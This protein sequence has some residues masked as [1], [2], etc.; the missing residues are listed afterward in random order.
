MAQVPYNPTQQVPSAVPE[1]R[2]PDDYQHLNTNPNMFG[3]GIAQGLGAIGQGIERSSNFLDKVQADNAQAQAIE[4]TQKMLHGTGEIDPATGQIDT[5][6]LGKKGQDALNAAPQFHRDIEDKVNEIR[7]QLGTA[8]ARLLFDQEIRRYRASVI[9][10]Q[11]GTHLDQQ[12]QV[13]GRTANELNRQQAVQMA[14][15]EDVPSEVFQ[16]AYRMAFGANYGDAVLAGG[17]DSVNSDEA[18]Q[19]IANK[20]F[21]DVYLPRI[22]RLVALGRTDEAA[23]LMNTEVPGAP[24]PA[25]G[26]T[27]A[28][29]YMVDGSGTLKLRDLMPPTLVEKVDQANQAQVGPG[30]IQNFLTG[31]SQPQTSVKPGQPTVISQAANTP[32]QSAAGPNVIQQKFFDQAGVNSPAVQSVLGTIAKGESGGNFFALGKG[33]V[34]DPVLRNALPDTA[35]RTFQPYSYPPEMVKG[36]DQ[37]HQPAGAFQFMPG[38]WQSVTG[39]SGLPPQDFGEVNQ[40]KAA[41]ALLNQK[42]V[43]TDGGTGLPALEQDFQNKQV[44]WNSLKDTWTSLRKPSVTGENPQLAAIQDP[45]ARAKA[46]VDLKYSE[47]LQDIP[48]QFAGNQQ[49]ISSATSAA[50]QWHTSEQYKIQAAAVKQQDQKD[51]GSITIYKA[52]T[53]TNPPTVDQIRQAGVASNLDPQAIEGLISMGK[54]AQEEKISGSPLNTGE[55]FTRLLGPATTGQLSAE[56]ILNPQWDLTTYGRKSLVETADTFRK[57]SPADIAGTNSYMGDMLSEFTNKD[58][59]ELQA[60]QTTRDIVDPL[61]SQ[62]VGLFQAKALEVF[63]DARA[64]NATTS[65]IL[66]SSQGIGKEVHANLQAYW[67][68]LNK[69]SDMLGPAKLPTLDLGNLEVPE[70]TSRDMLTQLVGSFQPQQQPAVYSNLLRVVRDP[71]LLNNPKVLL[72][73]QGVGIQPQTLYTLVNTKP[74]QKAVPEPYPGAATPELSLAYQMLA[75][76]AS[77]QATSKSLSRLEY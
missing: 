6:F 10:G 70:G 22:Q 53:G 42:Y 37:V 38:T 69:T 66:D 2:L 52:V 41:Q 19:T 43:G 49:A 76:A 62:K 14:A 35:S 63:R 55:D 56:A 15:R 24:T 27:P 59:R 61:L 74:A 17:A 72:Q 60:L 51:Q 44:N 30:Y 11:A 58:P 26:E 33:G 46:D 34:A 21:Q 8:N 7:S 20:S 5:G 23:K 57:L 32:D 68:T 67:N 36:T 65:Q 18:R 47:M 16:H 31:W 40:I 48:K 13:A 64:N 1:E 73:F 25:G 77:S 45:I 71:N 3:G 4:Q 29:Q 54:R 50:N 39:S 12:A 9:L 28:P 75:P